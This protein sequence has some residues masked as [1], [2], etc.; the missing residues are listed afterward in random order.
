MVA[1]GTSQ[2]T[3]LC[4]V[5]GLRESFIYVLLWDKE[6]PPEDQN[7]SLETRLCRV[8]D[9]IIQVR[10]WDFLVPQQYIM[11]DTFSRPLCDIL[12]FYMNSVS[13]AYF[14]DF[15]RLFQ[16]KNN[17]LTNEFSRCR[18]GCKNSLAPNNGSKI[19]FQAS[20]L[21]L[22]GFKTNVGISIY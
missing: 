14:L 20:I 4:T 12:R 2:W 1:P 11:M 19:A 3:K 6:I 10:G 8:S 16:S 22:L 7:N 15:F 9:E 5:A 18:N 21:F 17:K 13:S